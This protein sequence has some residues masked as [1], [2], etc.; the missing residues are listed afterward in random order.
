M[1]VKET[2]VYFKVRIF[3][4]EGILDFLDTPIEHW[5]LQ[6]ER[7]FYNF[8]LHEWIY[9]EIISFSTSFKQKYSAGYKEN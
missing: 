1:H 9:N 8:A 6:Y 5:A 3:K 2:I 7:S 4:K